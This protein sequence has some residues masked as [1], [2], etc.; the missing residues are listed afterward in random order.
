MSKKHDRPKRW[1]RWQI[2]LSTLLLLTGFI[3]V[4][5]GWWVDRTRLQNE[6]IESKKRIQFLETSRYFDESMEL[7][8]RSR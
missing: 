4:L 8:L 6:V 2:S 7:Q 1:R 5:V 3:A